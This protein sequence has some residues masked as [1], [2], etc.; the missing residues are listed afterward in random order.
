MC[1]KILVPLHQQKKEIKRKGQDRIG[2]AS[3]GC[4]S[5]VI[6]G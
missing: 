5:T 2:R 4:L 6:E 1:A 3:H